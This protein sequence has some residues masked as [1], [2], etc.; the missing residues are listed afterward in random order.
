VSDSSY[1]GIYDELT[2][3][4]IKSRSI[5]KNIDGKEH[6]YII[7]M[8]ECEKSDYT[9]SSTF[10]RKA[11]SFGKIRLL[12]FLKI[13]HVRIPPLCF[14]DQKPSTYGAQNIAGEKN[15]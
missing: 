1:R 2:E 13:H 9:I 11:Y 3:C 15:P 7:K 12:P 6:E 5:A 14:R 4:P 8:G 10:V